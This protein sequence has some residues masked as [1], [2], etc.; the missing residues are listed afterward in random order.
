MQLTRRAVLIFDRCIDVLVYVAL[1]LLVFA[2]LSV[3]ADVIF[4]YFLARPISWATEVTEYIL[5]HITF[6]GTA[7]LL[8]KE[9]HV[10]V[11]VLLMRLNPKNQALLNLVTSSIC[12]VVCLILTW[13]GA[14]AVL[15]LFQ[16]HSIIPKQLDMPK[17]LMFIVIPLGYFMLFG[18]FLRRAYGFLS[19]W[20]AVGN[21]S[22]GFEAKGA[23]SLTR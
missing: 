4:R 15:G 14:V 10:N 7:W 2:W 9:G 16:E 1:G 21:K 20:R 13:Y 12:A 5:L 6:L 19:T 18:Q 8:R 23:V 3:S 22:R 17:Y 11:D